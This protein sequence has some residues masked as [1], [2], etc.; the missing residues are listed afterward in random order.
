MRTCLLVEVAEL[1]VA[2]G[3]LGALQRLA[4]AL[5]RV[6]IGRHLF[7]MTNGWEGTPPAGEHKGRGVASGQ[8]GRVTPGGVVPLRR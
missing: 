8:A 4:G 2:V 1:A 5:Q 7:D 6:V 3:V